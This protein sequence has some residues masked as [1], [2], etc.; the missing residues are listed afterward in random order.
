[1]PRNIINEIDN[2]TSGAFAYAN[3]AVLIPG[4][5][6]ADKTGIVNNVNVFDDNGVFECTK[7]KIKL[8]E[9]AVGKSDDPAT[10]TTGHLG[11][12]GR[13][14]AHKLLEL[15]YTV[16]FKKIAADD[17]GLAALG[18]AD[19]WAPMKDKSVY[20]FRYICLGDYCSAAAI[21]QITK[22]ATFLDR[23]GISVDSV[24]DLNNT[25][26]GECI[27]LVDI[28]ETNLQNTQKNQNE[29]IKFVKDQLK[30]LDGKINKYAAVFAP[31]VYYAE[32][33]QLSYPASFHY[34]ACAARAFETVREWW[35]V[36][37][38]NRGF[39]YK[40]VD[41]TSVKLGEIAV[42][43]LQPRV[44]V[45][46]SGTEKGI[47]YSVNIVRTMRDGHYIWGNRTAERLHGAQSDNPGL[48]ASHFL[49]IRQ[50]CCTLKK[51]LN[52]QCDRHAYNPNNDILWAQFCDSIRPL[53]EK[54]KT[55]EGIEDYDIIKVSND[56]KGLLTAA[57]RIV[58]IAA[59]ED[60]HINVYL[61]DSISGIVANVEEDFK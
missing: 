36:S 9:D 17:T 6:E 4:A 35:A 18:T 39:C 56:K 8:F 22:L 37:G 47:E 33:T 50:L 15:G 13:F 55:D 24:A 42:N 16:L 58:P 26:R 5:L 52:R 3:F 32:N 38:Y 12:R 14:L 46:A 7:D 41:H 53:L 27:A 34:L 30:T 31:R 61:E 10:G 45:A 11:Q 25:G 29:Y 60:F 23:V 28:D 19:F 59:V 40:T 57:V 51:E 1:M 54:M 20:D 49:N 43:A 44:A 48:I 21:D 2:T